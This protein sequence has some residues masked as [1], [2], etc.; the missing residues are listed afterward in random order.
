MWSSNRIASALAAA[1]LLGL[2][3]CGFKPLYGTDSATRA[4]ST[5]QQFAAV[6]IPP[7]ADRLGQQLR[8]M[9]IDELHPSGAAADYRYSLLVTIKELDL[10]LG[11]QENATS[12]RGQVRLTAKYRLVDNQSGK[13]LLDETLRAATGYNILLNQ[14][15]SVLSADDARQKGLEEV[16]TE[17][18]KHLAIYFHTHGDR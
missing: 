11:L 7:M 10:N 8:N 2:A 13:T 17:I 1:L 14:F 6:E 16:S 9:L 18:A 4:P 12:T 5:M 15:G 3:G